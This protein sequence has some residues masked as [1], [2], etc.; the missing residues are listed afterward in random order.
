[1]QVGSY[2][3][4]FDSKLIPR[5]LAR[6][7]E[8]GISSH[9]ITELLRALWPY[10]KHGVRASAR[11][12]LS[13]ATQGSVP[14]LQNLSLQDLEPFGDHTPVLE[15]AF[16]HAPNNEPA[17]EATLRWLIQ[18]RA[19]LTAGFAPPQATGGD[20]GQAAP[21]EAQGQGSTRVNPATRRDSQLKLHASLDS[22][23]RTTM[24]VPLQPLIEAMIPAGAHHRVCSTRV[25]PTLPQ[26][27]CTRCTR[28][29][30]AAPTMLQARSLLDGTR[31]STQTAAVFT[32]TKRC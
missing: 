23:L 5:A 1:M 20:Q 29:C 28:V 19:T 2:C 26:T 22:T 10:L 27:L 16:L 6:Q 25:K 12:A 14:Y 8:D 15:R 4:E 31:S 9:C 21:P 3:S 13:S 7:S 30:S 32:P 11:D 18:P 24:H 17:L